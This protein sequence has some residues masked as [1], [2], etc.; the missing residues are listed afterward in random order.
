MRWK[1]KRIVV[2]L[3]AALWVTTV[4]AQEVTE[5][6]QWKNGDSLPG[7]LLESGPGTVSWASQCFSDNLVIN[8]GVLDSILFPK[9]SAPPTEA[10]QIHTASDDVWTADLIGADDNIFL[11]SSKRHG[12]VRVNRDAIYAFNRRESP[13]LIFDGSQLTAWESRK[14]DAS[15]VPFLLDV[16]ARSSWIPNAA[17]YL[18]TNRAKAS[19]FCAFNFPTRFEI[20]LEFTATDKPPG[21]VLAIGES[22]RK[23]LR[24]ETWADEVVV[25][26][27]VRF[28][29]VLTFRRDRRSIRLR[30]MVDGVDRTL[31]VFDATGQLLVNVQD[32]EPITAK[33]GLFIR[34][35]GKNLTI[36]RLNVYRQPSLLT[37]EARQSIDPSK[38]QVHMTEGQVVYGRLFVS[39]NTAHV[40]D[41]QGTQRNISIAEV[42]RVIQPR[43]KPIAMGEPT[44]LTYVDGAVLRGKIEQ[45]KTDRVI[46]RTTFADEP[47]PCRLVGA[48]QLQLGQT[49]ETGDPS[50]DDDRLFYATGSLRGSV[51]FEAKNASPILWQSE[52]AT[53]PVRLANTGE[54]GIERSS[55]RVSRGSPFDRER[56]PNMLHLKNGEV[57]PCQVSSYDEKVFD[58][59]SP[60][61]TEKQ[62]DSP[63]VKAIEFKPSEHRD[64]NGE[65]PSELDRW[66]NEIRE[67][68]QKSAWGIDSVKLERALT[69]PRFNRDSP[70]SHLLVANTGDFKRGKLLTIN[71]QTIQ[72]DSK[73][74]KLTI[75][76]DRVARV[77]D[78]SKSQSNRDHRHAGPEKKSV[79]VNDTS[80]LIQ[81]TLADRSILIFEPLKSEDGM[82]LGHSPIYGAVA[83]P[84]NSIHYLHVGDYEVESFKS[85][86]EEWVVR[87]SKEPEFGGSV[88]Y[89]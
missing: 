75:P 42:D 29:R 76:V 89:E 25:I 6:L 19:I 64:R 44:E 10:F 62:I 13:N 74:R 72:F 60:F 23:A 12:L 30:L 37:D 84:M 8:I 22:I 38:P 48:S 18:Q 81:I 67:V 20:D 46:L 88:T 55:K 85:V 82:L 5:R 45:V 71:E 65:Q 9:Q 17:G 26:Q 41:A 47:V 78:V 68:E 7:K 36:R 86:F 53:A 58:F 4:Q 61:I 73:L 83:V 1:S 15:K 14:A 31:N 87:P 43:V 11:F 79:A 39:E 77:V 3:M 33:S 80:K 21:F 59:Q 56:F 52:G 57:I 28:M 24:L 2:T 35:R 66:L 34:N 49:A 27:N 63:F 50:K 54:Y 40:L 16:D 32:L 51:L 69:V 70:P